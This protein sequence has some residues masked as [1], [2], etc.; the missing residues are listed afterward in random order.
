M[1]E[2]RLK[3]SLTLLLIVAL[4]LTFMLVGGAILMYRLPRVEVEKRAELQARAESASRLLD[5]YTS[6]IDAQ[7]KSMV[8]VVSRRSPAEQQVYL[9]ALVGEG[10]EFDAAYIVSSSGEVQMI[11]LPAKS[12][13]AAAELR[14][15]DFSNSPLFRSI[16][17]ATESNSPIAGA[18]SDKYLS[19]LSGKHAIGVAWPMGDK[20]LICEASLER[21]LKLLKSI[22][23]DKDSVVVTLD[24]RGQWLSSS[25]DRPQAPFFDYAGLPTF[26]A[27]VAGQAL[28][29]YED[30]AG[31]RLL[32]GGT[33]SPQLGWAIA[34]ATPAG[35]AISSYRMTVM[36]VFGG[37]FGALVLSGLLAPLWAWRISQSLNALADRAPA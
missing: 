10:E 13:H 17:A 28:P 27:I 29:A 11:G 4:T 23:I 15:L 32:V 12:R 19:V 7:I 8:R 1:R 16:Q 30:F 37:F 34:V 36:L 14:G 35:M 9:D 26:Q 24:G 3:T 25:L 22:P 21:V 33:L 6:G 18:W 5:Y 31:Q 20:V 2:L